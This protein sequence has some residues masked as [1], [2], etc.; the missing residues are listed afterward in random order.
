MAMDPAAVKAAADAIIVDL[1][2]SHRVLVKVDWKITTDPDTK[3]ITGDK[4]LVVFDTRQEAADDALLVHY[5]E[6]QKELEACKQYVFPHPKVTYFRIE[7]TAEAVRP[8]LVAVENE[9]EI[10]DPSPVNEFDKFFVDRGWEYYINRAIE[11]E[12]DRRAILEGFFNIL[13]SQGA[14]GYAIVG[15]TGPKVRQFETIKAWVRVCVD[16]GQGWDAPGGNV[17]QLGNLVVDQMRD[18]IAV[19]KRIPIEIVHQKLLVVNRDH[20]KRGK[21]EAEVAK[22]AERKKPGGKGGKSDHEL[23]TVCNKCGTKGH[24]ARD[25]YAGSA[26]VDA[27]QARSQDFQSGG[28]RPAPANSKSPGGKRTAAATPKASN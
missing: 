13:E 14:N 28:T 22:T 27:Y 15:D 1:K 2:S 17:L 26:K 11:H 12:D 20:D 23:R 10:P 21:V 5:A 3:K 24:Y 6:G 7:H 18:H 9:E 25:C 19:E 4:G 8:G 16:Y